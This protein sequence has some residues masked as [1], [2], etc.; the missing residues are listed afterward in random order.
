MPRPCACFY[1]TDPHTLRAAWGTLVIAGRNTTF[2][3]NMRRA[4][5]KHW[6]DGL[7]AI[8]GLEAKLA[9][10]KEQE[11]EPEH[12]EERLRRPMRSPEMGCRRPRSPGEDWSGSDA[13]GAFSDEEPRRAGAHDSKSFIIVADGV[14]I[15]FQR[16][17]VTITPCETDRSGVTYPEA[18][19][20]YLHRDATVAQKP[21]PNVDGGES[22]GR[23]SGR[24]RTR[25]PEMGVGFHHRPPSPGGFHHRPPSPGGQAAVSGR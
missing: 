23:S 25:S 4:D 21:E 19:D 3:F 5:A 8:A 7:P 16:E 22:P 20:M 10:S 13:S 9:V 24:L 12:Q 6:T 1:P 11:P 18:A 2:S 14:A 15:V 17:K